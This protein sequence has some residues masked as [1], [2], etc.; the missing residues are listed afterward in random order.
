M[1]GNPA[2]NALFGVVPESCGLRRLDGGVRSHMRTGLHLHGEQPQ[3]PR[4]HAQG[5]PAGAR[6]LYERALAW[7]LLQPRVT[8]RSL[9]TTGRARPLAASTT[10]NVGPF[11]TPT[12][13]RYS[14]RT[15]PASRK[16]RGISKPSFRCSKSHHRANHAFSRASDSGCGRVRGLSESFFP[17]FPS[18]KKGRFPARLQS[19]V[20]RRKFRLH[21]GHARTTDRN[22]RLSKPSK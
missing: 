22:V 3:Q 21:R 14:N 6:P 2:R 11:A 9:C 16:G 5:D 7:L 15:A 13:H 4:Q 12:R 10:Y 20:G 1:A 19:L 17:F 18:I 8:A